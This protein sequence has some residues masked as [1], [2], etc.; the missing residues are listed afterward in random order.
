M[1]ELAIKRNK[2]PSNPNSM[3]KT[4]RLFYVLQFFFSEFNI[5]YPKKQNDP[6][7]VNS[8]I[9]LKTTNLG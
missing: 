8:I 3:N 7:D 2:F 9:V 6:I 4:N 5:R 1:I